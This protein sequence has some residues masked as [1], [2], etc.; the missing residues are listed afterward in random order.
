MLTRPL[1]TLIAAAL[2]TWPAV[3]NADRAEKLNKAGKQLF[4][5]GD[6]HAALT[7]FEQA[8]REKPRAKYFFNICF[9]LNHL[10]Q[11]AQALEACEKVAANGADTRLVEKARDLMAKIR[12]QLPAEPTPPA[13]PVPDQPDPSP[14][15]PSPAQPPTASPGNTAP[16]EFFP[17]SLDAERRPSTTYKWSLGAEIAGL[18][19]LGIGGDVDG[20]G[21]YAGSGLHVRVFANFLVWD[22]A[23]LG[24]QTYF[25]ATNLPSASGDDDRALSIYDLGGGLFLHK[26][27][28]SRLSIAPMIGAHFAIQQPRFTKQAL[29]TVGG[30]GEI[31][32]AYSAGERGQHVFTL[33]PGINVYAKSTDSNNISASELGLDEASS[34]VSVGVGYTHRFMT[35][36]GSTPIF[37]LE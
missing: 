15:A 1:I 30:R 12:A 8:S 5:D 33:T 28:T 36:F 21:R 7:K 17:V 31:S 37:T 24:V 13:T 25:A 27:L 9:T 3:A 22:A 10:S 6:L 34:S 29:V 18:A 4:A 2:L 14:E 23:H 16:P 19:N 20:D 11:P 32:L 26:R 35:P